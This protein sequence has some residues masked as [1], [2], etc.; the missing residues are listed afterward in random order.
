MSCRPSCCRTSSLQLGSQ[1]EFG[2]HQT[3]RNVGFLELDVDGRYKLTQGTWNWNVCEYLVFKT[4]CAKFL[5]I[6]LVIDMCL[7]DS[8]F[9]IF[10]DSSWRAL[11]LGTVH[12]QSIFVFYRF[13]INI[14]ITNINSVSGTCTYYFHLIDEFLCV[15]RWDHSET[16]GLL[17]TFFWQLVYILNWF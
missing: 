8:Q 7:Q 3:D 9:T 1:L 2:G 11:F 5:H 6:S 16:A 13:S 12:V 17:F 15:Q 14:I 10:N 4:Q